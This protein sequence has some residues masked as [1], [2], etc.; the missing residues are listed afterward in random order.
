M[1]FLL[2]CS[3]FRSE[4]PAVDGGCTNNCPDYGPSWQT[5]CPPGERC[6]EV[7]NAC[8]VDVGL[9]YNVGC[10]GDGTPGA[11]QCACTPGPTLAPG[12]STFWVIVDGNYSSCDPW[13]PSCLTEGLSITMKPDCSGVRAEFTAGNAGNPDGQ[14]DSYDLDVQNGYGGI[15]VTFNPNLECAADNAN[16]DCRKLSCDMALC[17]DAYST[18]TGGG[19]GYSPQVG[20]QDTFAKDKGYTLTLCGEWQPSCTD[21]PACP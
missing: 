2:A 13:T 19:C 10:D 4:D 17:P 15:P 9:T 14:F 11:P 3:L 7:K 12:A 20:C 6:I 16:H 1:L 5:S 8:T 18:P 21:M